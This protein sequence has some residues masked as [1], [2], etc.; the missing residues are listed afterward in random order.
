MFRFFRR[1]PVSKVRSPVFIVGCGR[2]G[3]TLLFDILKRHPSLVA[4]K[5]HPDGEDHVGWIKH[6]G[7]L[8][9]GLATPKGDS[10][11]VGYP[12][13]LHMDETDV[14]DE[15]RESMHR[16]YV[17]NVLRRRIVGRVLN[18]CPHI[19]N[20]L[21]YVRAIFPDARFV[22]I[23]RE[24]VAV[25]ASWVKVMETVPNLVLY[26]PDSDY[27]CFWVFEAGGN[28]DNSARF[29]RENRIFPGGGL[30]HL[31]DYWTQVNGNIPRQLSDAPGQLLSIRYEDL[32][33]NSDQVLRKVT[34]FCSLQP[35]PDV[36]IAIQPGRNQAYR[37][38]LTNAQL[39][40][41]GT[42]CQPVAEQFGYVMRRET[43]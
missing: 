38:L 41:I 13:C 11:H 43:T 15:I 39:E 17:N 35:F 25:V 26:W 23:I 27:P 30:L 24:P 5:G 29:A 34:D 22:H 3:T 42:R 18:K 32:V 6:G 36:P 31:A 9:A 1:E 14:S 7:A 10:G 21:R 4:T 19:S 33:A 16:Y 28:R 37:S 40:S 8:I 20:K 2:S 12:Y